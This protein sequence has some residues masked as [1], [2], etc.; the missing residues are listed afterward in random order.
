VH[1]IPIPNRSPDSTPATARRPLPRR[2]FPPTSPAKAAVAPAASQRNLTS[3]RLHPAAAPRRAAL[4]LVPMAATAPLPRAPVSS[5]ASR[6]V[7]WPARSNLRT[8]AAPPAGTLGWRRRQPFPAV[9]I[10]PASA[11]S[12][13]PALAVDPEV[14]WLISPAESAPFLLLVRKGLIAVRNGD[15][16]TC[17]SLKWKLLMNA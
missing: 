17:M 12:T 6:A 14:C 3:P 5:P 13:P 8:A 15:G 1:P 9:S 7:L 11:Q 2:R 16:L 10:T 4:L